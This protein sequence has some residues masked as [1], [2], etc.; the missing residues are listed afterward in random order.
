MKLH[1]LVSYRDSP[2]LFAAISTCVEGD[3][4][5]H[6]PEDRVQQVQPPRSPTSPLGWAR[7]VGEGWD[8]LCSLGAF[9]FTG[10]NSVSWMKQFVSFAYRSAGTPTWGST[11][12]W[13]ENAVTWNDAQV[14]RYYRKVCES[15]Q[16]I[17]WLARSWI[18][19]KSKFCITTS[20]IWWHSNEF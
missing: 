6:G 8:C 20:E 11:L 17:C 2:A 1:G 12:E 16:I 9:D 14:G 4:K 19:V 18:I 13:H 5:S 15:L 3:D 10:M 7:A